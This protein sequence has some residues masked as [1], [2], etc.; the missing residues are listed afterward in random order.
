MDFGRIVQMLIN[1]FMG[2]AINTG[3]NKGI[4]F[5]ARK[6]KPVAEMTPA[7]RKQAAANRDLAKRA[8]QASRIARKI[9]R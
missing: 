1:R 9:G 2:R 6:G 4:E 8:R 3:I 7:D 5:A